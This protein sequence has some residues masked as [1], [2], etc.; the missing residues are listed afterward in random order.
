[1]KME[2]MEIAGRE[3]KQLEAESVMLGGSGSG[4]EAQQEATGEVLERLR[5]S[6]KQTQ[7]GYCNGKG[8]L[9][10]QQTKKRQAQCER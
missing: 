2:Q 6:P 3:Q 4:D 8:T 7:K 5:A 10:K 9:R 1:M